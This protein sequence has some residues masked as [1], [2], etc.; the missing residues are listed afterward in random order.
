M[1]TPVSYRPP[2]SPEGITSIAGNSFVERSDFG[3]RQ[4][5]SN[6]AMPC[7]RCVLLGKAQPVWDLV[8]S[9]IKWR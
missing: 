2:G 8:S 7:S 1:L 4:T 5:D 3:V 6:P 9:S